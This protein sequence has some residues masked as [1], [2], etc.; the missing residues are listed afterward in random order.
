MNGRAPRQAGVALMSAIFL[1]VV[2]AS[3]GVYAVR[4]SAVQQ[5][6]ASLALLSAQAF[7]A[8]KTGIAWGAHQAVNLGSC[9][10]VTLNLTEGGSAGFTVD[11][12]C[13]Q[14]SHVEAGA[15]VQVYVIDVL[16]EYGLYGA[17]DYVSRRLQAKVTDES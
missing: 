11:V 8:A 7:H 14:T 6:T 5:H 3:L 2:L 12:S 10:S 17:P 9:G 13:A 1:L 15:A 4:M 16:A